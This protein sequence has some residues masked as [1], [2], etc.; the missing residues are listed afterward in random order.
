[1]PSNIIEQFTDALSR[2][3]TERDLDAIVSLFAS[4]CE[5][6]NVV[7]P[8]KFHGPEGAR[9]FWTKYRDTFHELKS[10]FRNEITSEMRAALEW[11]TRATSADGRPFEYD[12]VSVLEMD[13]SKIKR[14]RAYFDAASL[15][16]HLESQSSAK[17]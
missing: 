14:F 10:T 7:V 12:G 8:E 4:D 3:E 5:V 9:E 15:A 2:L 16:R 17:A 13:G 6:G 1:M 11:T